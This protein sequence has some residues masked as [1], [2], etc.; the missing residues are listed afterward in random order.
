MTGLQI[1]YDK[2]QQT[3]SVALDSELS[4]GQSVQLTTRFTGI[5]NSDLAGFYRFHLTPALTQQP[6]IPTLALTHS[7]PDPS[8]NHNLCSNLTKKKVVSNYYY[9]HHDYYYH[10]YYYYHL[11]IIIYLLS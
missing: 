4:S 1:T 6:L 2:D 5:L 7:N 11:F 9:Y 3:C 8:T 10:H